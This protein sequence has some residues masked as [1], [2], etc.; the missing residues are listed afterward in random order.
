VYDNFD[1]VTQITKNGAVVGSYGYNVLNQRIWKTT[2]SG[3]TLYVYSPSGQLLYERGPQSSTAYIWLGGELL[4]I[5]R[6]G[7]FYAS[8]NDHHG[9]PEVLTDAAGQVAWRAVNEAYGRA[10]VQTNNIG[11]FNMGLPGQ[12]MDSE[13]GLWF[14]WNR[15]Y[16]PLIG[17]YIQSDPIGLSGGIN[18]YAYA[19]GNPISYAD[20]LGLNSRQSFNWGSNYGPRVLANAADLKGAPTKKEG[21]LAQCAALVKQTV[22]GGL[23]TTTWRQGG[24]PS[25]STP[26]GTAVA[27]FNDEGKYNDYETGQHAA[28]FL[29]FDK[30]G[31]MLVLEQWKGIKNDVIDIRPIPMTSPSGNPYPS[32]NA[33]EYNIV[34]FPKSN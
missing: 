21:G 23:S 25:S 3:L 9:R 4:G 14:N 27:T 30:Q 34:Y 20:P 8:H 17:R 12:Y 5:M 33:K 11:G 6:G 16:D 28:I 29:G 13:S 1:R 26:I 10:S 15:Y 31:R 22:G 2:A 19:D 18:T 32:N 24:V 7:N